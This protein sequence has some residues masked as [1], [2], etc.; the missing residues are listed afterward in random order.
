MILRI[1]RI[2]GGSGCIE[3]VGDNVGDG[4]SYRDVDGWIGV[5][6]GGEW[7]ELEEEEKDGEEGELEWVGIVYMGL[8]ECGILVIGNMVEGWVWLI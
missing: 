6:G 2:R 4:C 1:L 8:F 5:K 7:G 3:G